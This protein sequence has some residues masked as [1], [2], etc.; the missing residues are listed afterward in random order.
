M[1]S[2]K[3]NIIFSSFLVLLFLSSCKK[4]DC[5]D[6]TSLTDPVYFQFEAKNYAWGIF[7]AGWFIDQNGNFDYFNLPDPWKEPDSLGYISKNDLLTN[8]EQ[9]DSVVYSISMHELQNKVSLIDDIDENKLSEI[10]QVAADTGTSSLY[11]YKWD[12]VKGKYKRIILETEGDFR[13]FNLDPEAQELASWLIALGKEG[14]IL[15]WH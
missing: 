15:D 3:A 7:H 8:L 13:Q 9:A 1:K 11:C 6:P 2:L 4:E 14:G 10:E 12:N 5:G